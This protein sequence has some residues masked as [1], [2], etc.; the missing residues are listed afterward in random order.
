MKMDRNEIFSFI[1]GMIQ[2]FYRSNDKVLID[3]INNSTSFTELNLVPNEVAR[4][5]MSCEEKYHDDLGMEPYTSIQS[6]VDALMSVADKPV[7]EADNADESEGKPDDNDQLPP[8]PESI[9]IPDTT[10]EDVSVNVETQEEQVESTDDTVENT[11][12]E[13]I[14]GMNAKAE[15]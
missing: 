2:R 15:E 11:S 14:P 5:V 12:E 7:T 4:I 10:P 9:E 6:V 3:K 13:E 8:P 1:Q